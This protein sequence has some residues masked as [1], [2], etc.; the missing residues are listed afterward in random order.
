AGVNNTLIDGWYFSK[1]TLFNRS[2][3]VNAN[4]ILLFSTSP[5]SKE[6]EYLTP[7]ILSA[8]LDEIKNTL[9]PITFDHIPLRNAMIS[10]AGIQ[11]RN[12]PISPFLL[13]LPTSH[14]DDNSNE[15]D[16][17]GVFP[18]C[19]HV[20]LLPPPPINARLTS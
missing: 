10:N 8:R 11:P 20:F 17:A 12:A 16:R 1:F 4:L 19:G 2:I 13:D 3:V 15:L 9:C 5:P 18:T 14:V 6:K 7:E